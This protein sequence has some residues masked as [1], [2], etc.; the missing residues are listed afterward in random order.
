MLWQEFRTAIVR[1]KAANLFTRYEKGKDCFKYSR[2]KLFWDLMVRLIGAASDSLSS[3]DAVYG[4]GGA[5]VSTILKRIRNDK[6]QQYSSDKNCCIKMDITIK[7]F[8]SIKKQKCTLLVCN[9]CRS[10]LQQKRIAVVVVLY[11][12]I[13]LLLLLLLNK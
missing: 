2:R 3:I 12:S 10:C 4:H 1:N 13:L 11:Y 8:F 5:S 9:L 7:T 6:R